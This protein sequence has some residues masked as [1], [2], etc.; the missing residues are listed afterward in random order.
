MASG[1]VSQVRRLQNWTPNDDIKCISVQKHFH[2]AIM[3]HTQ[4]QQGD[5]YG[6]HGS[7]CPGLHVC[8]QHRYLP[9]IQNR[10]V[11][12]YEGGIGSHVGLQATN[13][14]YL[15]A[16]TTVNIPINGINYA[17]LHLVLDC[18]TA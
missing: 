13:Y 15:Q 18:K 4:G 6:T 11:C 2:P 5:S 10:V 7:K 8:W 9:L 1:L 12:L 17:C 14:V 16:A 3:K